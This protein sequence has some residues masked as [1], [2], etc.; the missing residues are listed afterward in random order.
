MIYLASPYSHPSAEVRRQRYRAVCKAAGELMQSGK[1]VFSPIA[2][3]HGITLQGIDGGW[4]HWRDFDTW[5]LRR[6]HHMIVL[7]LEGWQDSEGIS[8]E[9]EHAEQLGISVEYMDP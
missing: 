8:H 2:H 1:M 4:N 3:S 9:I 6:C 5:F 7:R